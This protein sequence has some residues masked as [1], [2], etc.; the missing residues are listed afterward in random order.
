M[1]KLELEAIEKM[2]NDKQFINSMPK[3][4]PGFIKAEL[5]SEKDKQDPTVITSE[6]IITVSSDYDTSK[7]DLTYDNVL[8]PYRIIKKKQNVITAKPE[9]K[10]E[11]TTLEAP[12]PKTSP[13]EHTNAPPIVMV[14]GEDGTTPITPEEPELMRTPDEFYKEQMTPEQYEAWKKR[15]GVK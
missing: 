6:L 7:S 14:P 15:T 8:I 5:K 4:F 9:Q 13:T 10:E 11:L 12:K 1:E 2:L 3:K